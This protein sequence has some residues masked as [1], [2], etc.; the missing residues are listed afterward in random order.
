LDFV[1]RYPPSEVCMGRKQS[2]ILNQN[3]LKLGFSRPIAQAECP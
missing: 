1:I 2:P 3:K